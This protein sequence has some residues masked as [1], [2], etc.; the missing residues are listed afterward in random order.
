MIH[1]SNLN[2]NTIYDYIRELLHNSNLHLM[3]VIFEYPKIKHNIILTK[4][5]Y[6]FNVL[7]NI[8]YVIFYINKNQ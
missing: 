4:P 6:L 3:N 8:Q 5:H 2:N 1:S 7:Y